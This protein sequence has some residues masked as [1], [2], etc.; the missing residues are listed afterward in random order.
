MKKQIDFSKKSSIKIGGVCEVELVQDEQKLPKDAYIL[1]GCNNILLSPHH[2]KLAMLGSNFEFIKQKNGLL[3]IG[4]ATKSSKILSYAKK[5]DIANFEL[6]Q[7][8]PGTLGGMLKMNAGLK[9]WEVFNHLVK[10]RTDKGWFAKN[11]IDFGYR[12]AKIEGIIF[13]GVFELEKGFDKEL[14]DKFKALR[15]NQP[16]QPS[17]GSCFKNPPGFSAGALIDQA[18]LKGK[19]LGDVAMSE[20]HANFL[21][22]LGNGTY[23]EACELIELVKAEVFKTSGVKLEEEIIIL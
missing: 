14:L 1:G 15:D 22:N 4:A 16:S 10:L 3:H 13:E 2:P 7:K 5:H 23:E 20:K 6:M 8:L 9:Q 18:G 17:C 21:V 19:R 12:Y 11:D